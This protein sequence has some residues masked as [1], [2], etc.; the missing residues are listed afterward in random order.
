M[1]LAAVAQLSQA[2]FDWVWRT[3]LQAAVLIALVFLVQLIFGR[4]L[5]ARWRY[6]LWLLVLLRL[7]MPMVPASAWS[8]FNLGKS[9]LAVSTPLKFQ[10][11][12]T[13]LP[14]RL[15]E[16]TIGAP[17]APSETHPPATRT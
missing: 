4:V 3:S 16:P 8:V 13:Y 12:A 2:L 7:S 14:G 9:V 5:S 11:E 15:P 6:G 10:A 1:N 17:G